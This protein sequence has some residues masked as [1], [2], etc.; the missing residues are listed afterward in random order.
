MRYDDVPEKQ[1]A[2]GTADL[3][4]G[5]YVTKFFAH[6]ADAFEDGVQSLERFSVQF[7]VRERPDVL[8]LN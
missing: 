5:N 4:I 2:S 7:R 6:I 8:G 3:E 1:Y